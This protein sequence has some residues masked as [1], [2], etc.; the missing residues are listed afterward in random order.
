M[1]FFSLFQ[2]RTSTRVKTIQ[3]RQKLHQQLNVE[4]PTILGCVD[5]DSRERLNFNEKYLVEKK[6]ELQAKSKIRER[7]QHER[8]LRAQ[9]RLEAKN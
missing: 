5:E 2:R 4:E 9:R 1:Y 8:A 7:I 6:Q 3:D